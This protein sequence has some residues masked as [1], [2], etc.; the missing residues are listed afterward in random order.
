MKNYQLGQKS[1]PV[2]YSGLL[3]MKSFANRVA[4]L[5]DQ[6][7]AQEKA[8][9]A[10]LREMGIQDQSWSPQNLETREFIDQYFPIP[11]SLEKASYKSLAQTQG[12]KASQ[13]ASK[14][15]RAKYLPRVG[16]FAESYLFQ[17]S[18]DTANGSTA[19]LYLQWNLF[20][21]SDYGSYSEA[22]LKALAAEKMNQASI[23]QEKAERSALVEEQQSLRANLNRLADS[24]RLLAEQSR[25]STTLFKNGSIGALQFVEIL[26]R[27]T[28][29]IAQETEAELALLKATAALVSKS[30]FEIPDNLGSRGKK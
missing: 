3:G 28:D 22:K 16:A 30:N 13:E 9:F 25:V 17:G 23:Q 4:G 1:N 26:N 5:I 27:R 14:M 2:G 15:E 6:W 29:L 8:A 11:S 18:R 21:P 19:G 7:Q 12:V 10:V 24:D 20:D